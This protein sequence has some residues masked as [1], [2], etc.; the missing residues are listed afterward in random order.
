MVAEIASGP[1]K[2]KTIFVAFLPGH[3]ATQ[4]KIT[5]QG[6]LQPAVAM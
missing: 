3:M 5:I 6:L 1:T 2:D 4:N